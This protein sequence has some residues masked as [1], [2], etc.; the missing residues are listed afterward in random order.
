MLRYIIER[1][2]LIFV[3]MF[4]VITLNFF[5][6]QLIEGSPFDN[7]KIT[8]VQIEMMKKKFGLNEPPMKQYLR[9]LQGRFGYVL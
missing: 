8:P 5:L 4:V 1:I 2:V 9:Y 7:G 6:L 3:T